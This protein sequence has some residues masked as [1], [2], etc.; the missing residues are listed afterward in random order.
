ML[1]RGLLRKV[2]GSWFTCD[3]WEG[4]GL[5]RRDPV[6]KHIA[7]DTV[8][9]RVNVTGISLSIRHICDSFADSLV[10]SVRLL[11]IQRFSSTS[12]VVLEFNASK[13]TLKVPSKL[14]L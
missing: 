9:R 3:G 6:G 13:V 1:L 11:G 7:C 12:T 8:P 10:I 5:L 14:R 4:R 2:G